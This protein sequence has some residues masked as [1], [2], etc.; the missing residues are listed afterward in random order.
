[1]F[2]VS[3]NA[4]I[5]GASDEPESGGD[6]KS[7]PAASAKGEIDEELVELLATAWK[8]AKR[9]DKGFA[10]LSEVGNIAGNRS[11]F[12][13]RNYGFKRLSDLFEAIDQFQ[14][15]RRDDNKHLY[16]KRLR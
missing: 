5:K 12:D 6:V 13:V 4:L 10:S 3:L 16:V 11:S 7:A 15:E 14:V 9:D 1:M 8:A 2:N